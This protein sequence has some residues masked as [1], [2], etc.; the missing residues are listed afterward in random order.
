MVLCI[1]MTNTQ[2]LTKLLASSPIAPSSERARDTALRKFSNASIL[3]ATSTTGA[4]GVASPVR[5]VT[6]NNLGDLGDKLRPF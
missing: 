2:P 1:R 5:G 6:D 4:R 3:R